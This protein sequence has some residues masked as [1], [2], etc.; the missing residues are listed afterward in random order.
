VPPEYSPA[1]VFPLPRTI[2]RMFD[3]TDVPEEFIMPGAH[4]IERFLVEE[5]IHSVLNTYYVDRKLCA[6]KLLHLNVTNRIAV[7]Y[8][9]VEIV[10]G[11]MFNLP[12][13]PQIEVFYGSLLIE[14][15]KM[16]PTF[17]PQVV[18]ARNAYCPNYNY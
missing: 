13:S 16:Q 1:S 3:Y 8:M 9:I 2:F 7:N 5:Q 12:K 10:I 14:L 11:Q 6:S 4:S 17:L 15:C 18:S